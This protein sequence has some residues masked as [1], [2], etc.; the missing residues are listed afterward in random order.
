MIYKIIIKAVLFKSETKEGK[1]VCLSYFPR[2]F[3]HEALEFFETHVSEARIAIRRATER[4]RI[5]ADRET[6]DLSKEERSEKLGKVKTSGENETEIPRY[7]A[8][9]AVSYIHK[10]REA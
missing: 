3:P 5:P 4:K 10:S 9:V 8:R 6:A 2:D 7:I 1:N